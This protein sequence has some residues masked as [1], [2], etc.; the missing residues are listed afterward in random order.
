MF[1]RIRAYNICVRIVSAHQ[2]QCGWTLPKEAAMV[3]GW[4]GLPGGKRESTACSPESWI[5]RNVRTYLFTETPQLASDVSLLTEEPTVMFVP[6]SLYETHG[7]LVETFLR[8]PLGGCPSI[9]MNNPNVK[10]WSTSVA[11]P[12]DDCCPRARKQTSSQTSMPT[13][14]Y[15]YIY[16][17]I[18]IY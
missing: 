13:H 2:L 9:Q 3:F 18:Y 4:S 17:Y 16:I 11:S 14:N 1:C 6:L 15:I 10:R 7:E 12:L 8:L 5:L